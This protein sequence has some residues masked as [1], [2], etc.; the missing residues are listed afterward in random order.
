M[1]Q[2]SAE[3]GIRACERRAGK[4]STLAVTADTMKSATGTGK[5]AYATKVGSDDV[6]CCG[7]LLGLAGRF[8]DAE[9]A[10]GPFV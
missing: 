3:F 5:I 6:S 10:L 1:K 4:L 7:V 8:W 2:R 9:I